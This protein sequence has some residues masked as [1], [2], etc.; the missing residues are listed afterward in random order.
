[1]SPANYIVHSV[2][3][4]ER[5]HS[6]K[7]AT[8]SETYDPSVVQFRCVIGT[9]KAD[10]VIHRNVFFVS[11]PWVNGDVG[12][13][14]AMLAHWNLFIIGHVFGRKTTCSTLYLVLE[15]DRNNWNND[16]QTWLNQNKL[17]EFSPGWPS[18]LKKLLPHTFAPRPCLQ[19]VVSW[20]FLWCP[21]PPCRWWTGERR[22]LCWSLSALLKLSY[23]RNPCKRSMFRVCETAC[24][25]WLLRHKRSLEGPW[26]VVSLV[27]DQ[28]LCSSIV[29]SWTLPPSGKATDGRMNVVLKARGTR[30]NERGARVIQENQL[31]LQAQC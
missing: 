22:L 12:F 25:F 1:M 14:F 2:D 5:Q 26:L 3:V 7:V 11:S 21:N 13:A 16:R 19:S 30:C 27:S 28:C 17:K 18:V 10:Q 9:L 20:D 29:T 31:A 15:A 24:K 8:H 23:M 6:L 4:F